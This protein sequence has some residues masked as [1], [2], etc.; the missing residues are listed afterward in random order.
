MLNNIVSFFN[1]FITD[2]SLGAVT[3][4]IFVLVWY[5]SSFIVLLGMQMG[6]SSE[7]GEDATKRT[8]KIFAESLRDQS[9]NREVLGKKNNKYYYWILT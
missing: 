2:E 9:N 4:I 8:S 3:Y 6:R 5:A 7:I 1:Q